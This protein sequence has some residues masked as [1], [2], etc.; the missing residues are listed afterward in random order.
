MPS[1]LSRPPQPVW[2]SP[3][4]RGPRTPRLG[5]PATGPRPHP[6]SPNR[7]PRRSPKP[8]AGRLGSG[9]GRKSSWD[10]TRPSRAAHTAWTVPCGVTRAWADHHRANEAAAVAGAGC[11]GLSWD[12]RKPRQD[13]SSVA[14]TRS[15]N[16]R[17][18]CTIRWVLRPGSRTLST[19]THGVSRPT[20]T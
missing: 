20:R 19:P 3:C 11:S 8:P 4:A 1:K 14:K 5:G 6:L 9:G 15:A 10:S 18:Q 2:P 16:P 7:R 17:S 13:G 12:H